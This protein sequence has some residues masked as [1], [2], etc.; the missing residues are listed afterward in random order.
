VTFIPPDR[1]P[2]TTTHLFEES[3]RADLLERRVVLLSGPIDDVAAGNVTTQLMFLDGAGD[4]EVYLRINSADGSLVAAAALIDTIDALGVPV[5]ALATRA[6]GPALA[7]LAVCDHRTASPHATLRMIEPR[8]N[9]DG[10][11]ATLVGHL[12]HYRV[13]VRAVYERVS[14]ASRMTADHLATEFE[15]GRY[16]SPADALALGLIDEIATPPADVRKLRRPM[17]FRPS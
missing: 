5:H 14:E 8:V 15:A 17:G 3:A 10:P 1:Q 12:E 4:D 2:V 6:E 16:L 13:A 9:F 11:A 7:V